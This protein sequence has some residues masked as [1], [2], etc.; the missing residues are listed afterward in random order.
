MT[1]RRP[2]LTIATVFVLVAIL[3]GC[4]R[5]QQRKARISARAEAYFKG[6]EYDKAKVEYLNLLRL[7]RNNLDPRA[8]QQLAL[9]WFEEGA[10][11]EAYPYLSKAREL[12]P[13][14]LEL[15]SKLATI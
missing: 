10:P 5:A 9:I 7:D 13:D 12:A 2:I 1:P 3:A 4:D 8:V 6:H 14:N 15:R 11:L